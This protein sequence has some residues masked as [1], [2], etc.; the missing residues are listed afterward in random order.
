MVAKMSGLGG[1]IFQGMSVLGQ[2]KTLPPD[3]PRIGGDASDTMTLV[4]GIILVVGILLISFRPSKRDR[5]E[6]Q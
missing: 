2:L 3:E 6:A 1:V 4:M 5:V